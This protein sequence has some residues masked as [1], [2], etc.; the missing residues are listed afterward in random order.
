M[1]NLFITLS[2]L[3]VST[4]TLFSQVNTVDSGGSQAMENYAQLATG[5]GSAYGSSMMFYNPKR[6]IDGTFYLFEN[7]NNTATIH[8][9]SNDKFLVKRIN[10]N[11]DRNSFEAKINQSDSIFSFTFNNI[12]KVVINNNTYIDG[13]CK[14]LYG[15]PPDDRYILGYSII[16]KY[17]SN[18]YFSNILHTL[19]NLKEPQGCFIIRCDK[20]DN[21]SKYFNTD[22][23]DKLEFIQMYSDGVKFAKDQLQL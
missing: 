10:L 13:C 17:C 14:N 15:S 20:K 22:S 23:I 19:I 21:N 7:W 6:Q 16:G 18:G 9:I 12:K 5:N 11:L 8:T 3:I 2:I 4:T 1:K